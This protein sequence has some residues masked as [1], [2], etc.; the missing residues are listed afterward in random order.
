MKRL[1]VLLIVLAALVA[2]AG[3]A[4]P[5]SAATVG[6]TAISQA[7]LDGDLHAISQSVPYQCYLQSETEATTG[8]ALPVAGAGAVSV[9]GGTATPATYSTAFAG[10]WLSHLVAATAVENANQRRG[11][12]TG[13]LALSAGRV[14]LQLQMTDYLQTAA[15]QCASA[16]GLTGADGPATVLASLPASFTATLVRQQANSIVLLSSVLGYRTTPAAVAAFYAAHRRALTTV[17][18][19]G[20]VFPNATAVA[21][22][23][24]ALAAGTSFAT[25]VGQAGGGE[26]CA[27]RAS[28]GT[29][30][31]TLDRLAPGQ[32]SQPV[33]VSQGFA[34]LQVVSTRSTPLANVL[35]LLPTIL[36]KSS[37]GER[38]V[39]ADL[40]QSHVTV[41][42][43]YG[44]WV[45]A[46]VFELVPPSAPP[47]RSVLNPGS[48]LPPG[49]SLTCGT[50]RLSSGAG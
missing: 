22:A 7:T 11:L 39:S 35:A 31:S 47:C 46:P 37:A 10:Y 21:S 8:E 15:T 25:V 13:P 19:A 5:D 43:R 33:P 24:Q 29:L 6:G 4:V 42:P 41:D 9:S 17:C 30:T 12:T 28:F 38:S 48:N 14:A 34:L 49:T 3:L 50:A 16:L 20:V 23:Q 36:P 2:A 1:A 40:R 27:P 18:V 45:H 44:R 26:Q 32:V